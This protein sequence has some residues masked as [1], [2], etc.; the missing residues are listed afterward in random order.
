MSG[1]VEQLNEAIKDKVKLFMKGEGWRSEA[2]SQAAD[3]GAGGGGKGSEEEKKDEQTK[4]EED[5][6]KQKE[7]AV[8]EA[9]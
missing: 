2:E 9:E 8:E 4:K 1:Q 7:K 5:E 6:K 3:G